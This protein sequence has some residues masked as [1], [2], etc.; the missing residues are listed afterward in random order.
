MNDLDSSTAQL[1]PILIN[2][3]YSLP[4]PNEIRGE[5]IHKLLYLLKESSTNSSSDAAPS[6][7]SNNASPPPY[8]L[9]SKVLHLLP[10]IV[11]TPGEIQVV[12]DEVLIISNHNKCKRT[13]S[14]A[15]QAAHKLASLVTSNEGKIHSQVIQMVLVRLNT[16]NFMIKVKL[17]IPNL[18]YYIIP[19]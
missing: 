16:T 2:L 18:F 7:S 6:T 17:F 9:I 13:V 11:S 12:L 10:L 5:T 8:F 4:V 3:Y 14:H 1:L 19:L 15:V